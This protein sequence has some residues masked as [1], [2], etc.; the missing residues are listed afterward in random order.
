MEYAKLNMACNLYSESTRTIKFRRLVAQAIKLLLLSA[1]GSAHNSGKIV[2]IYPQCILPAS[3][4][5]REDATARAVHLS[6]VV[7]NND[8]G[9]DTTGDQR[10]RRKEQHS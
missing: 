9:D 3:Q 1:G 7:D 8:E 6:V 2:G 4:F 5:L 10:E